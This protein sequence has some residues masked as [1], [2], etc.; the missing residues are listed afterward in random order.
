MIL[1]A[2]RIEIRALTLIACVSIG[3]T[4]DAAPQ[5]SE[6][7]E[8]ETPK[9]RATV[10][11][12]DLVARVR[13]SVA[14]IVAYDFAHK[15]VA[16][17]PLIMGTCRALVYV[18]AAI[19]TGGSLGSVVLLPALALLAYVAGLTYVAIRFYLDVAT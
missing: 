5:V 15:R 6:R 14:A 17:A 7:A 1:R 16:V 9:H 19:A 13:P 2:T 18:L 10:D 12:K 8:S 11:L 3:T 4:T